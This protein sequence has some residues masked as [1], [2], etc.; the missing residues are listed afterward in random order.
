MTGKSLVFHQSFERRALLLH[1]GRT[2]QLLARILEARHTA[3]TVG[4]LIALH[5]IL[6]DEVLLGHVLPSMSVEEFIVRTQRTFCGWPQALL[7]EKLDHDAFDASV[8]DR[9]FALNLRGWHAYAASLRSEVAWFGLETAR[10]NRP[11]TH[12]RSNDRVIAPAPI[13]ADVAGASAA[14]APA[15]DIERDKD[16][17]GP[18]FGECRRALATTRGRTLKR[19]VPA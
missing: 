3:E 14:A 1:L 15:R 19:A 7:D 4:E 16:E 12:H 8:R 18:D 17:L 11:R 6:E 9:L 10:A 13:R 2:L 5:P